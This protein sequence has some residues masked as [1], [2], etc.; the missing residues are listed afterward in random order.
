MITRLSAVFLALAA[1]AVSFEA[2]GERLMRPPR[3]TMGA[4]NLIPVQEIDEADWIW[5]E[6]SPAEDATVFVRFR[7]DFVA[8]GSP[9]V[10]DVSADERFVLMLDGE[11][12]G[13]GPHR[14]FVDHWNYQTYRLTPSAGTHML[15]AIVAKLG[16]ARPAAQTSWRPGF[17]LKAAGSYDAQLTTGRAAWRAAELKGTT[18]RKD[19]TS[20]T[21]GLVGSPFRVEGA[22][23]LDECPA[24][25]DFH[26]VR[27][28]RRRIVK[29]V[30]GARTPGW[31]LFPSALPDQRETVVR[32]GRFVSGPADL[33]TAMNA[34]L[35]SGGTVVIPA[36]REVRLLWDLGDYFC[37]YPELTTSGGAGAEVLWQWDE[38]LRTPDG[39]KGHRGAFVGKSMTCGFGDLFVSDGRPTAAFTTPWWR[40]GRWCELV[41][42]TGGE[43][44]TL[45]RLA[46]RETRY[47]LDVAMKFEADD[48]GLQRIA[49]LCRRT[50]ENCTHETLCDCPHWEQLMYCGDTRV[51][52]QILS[53]LSGDE[54]VRQTAIA[55]FDQS[56][57][58]D[59]LPAMAVPLMHG[60]DSSTY[61][62]CWV[63]MFGDYA[64]YGTD[65]A[66]LKAHLPGMRAA[67]DGIGLYEDGDGLVSNL[68]GW[69]YVDER[70]G[71]YGVPPGGLPGEAPGA[72]VNLQYLQALQSAADAEAAAGE[73]TMSLRWREKAE[74]TARTLRARF[75][76]FQTAHEL[77]LAVLT[78]V[79]GPSDYESVAAQLADFK[80]AGFGP[81]G[82]YFQYYLFETAFRIGHPELFFAHLEPWRKMLSVGLVTATENGLTECRSDCHAWSAG[83]LFFFEAGLAGVRPTGWFWSGAEIAP[84]PG[85]LKVLRSETPTPRGGI[86]LD[87]AFDGAKVKGTVEVPSGLPCDFVW[88]GRRVR[89][90]PGRNEIDF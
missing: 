50:M 54:R 70:L 35:K 53:A 72:L 38:S 66:W 22:S 77:C 32:P 84:Q 2:A 20:H 69:N 59:G 23:W 86:R 55:L 46:I 82:A 89:L 19:E 74:R 31:M 65:A 71:N 52:L 16:P 85:G 18:R 60:K 61:A 37:A 29:D 27:V 57:R 28:A 47:P 21:I 17:V 34:L 44:L 68:P 56:R 9:L 83:P 4:T 6:S 1:V 25:S 40:A 3:E 51:E 24:E 78:G 45:T 12:V 39:K 48:P 7:K 43:A 73:K 81:M 36:R 80:R 79:I 41:V 49:S 8:D 26:P 14:G 33:V 30:W 10:L 64:R 87:L 88:R 11:F 62:M 42:K 76:K 67:L 75:Q 58:N 13:R 5:S 63:M 90:S 15:E